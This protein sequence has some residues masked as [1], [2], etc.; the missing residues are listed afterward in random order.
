MSAGDRPRS[1]EL[2]HALKDAL[3]VQW[4]SADLESAVSRYSAE[5]HEVTS[6]LKSFLANCSEMVVKWKVEPWAEVTLSTR[7]EDALEE[8]LRTLRYYNRK[9]GKQVLQIGA[10]YDTEDCVLLAEDDEI[11]VGSDAGIQRIGFGFE[12]A[13]R[14]LLGGTWDKTFCW[15]P[16]VPAA[17]PEIR[18]P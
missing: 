5:G 3:S 14:A 11:L 9:I 15:K 1:V 12:N 10:V 17:Y 7:V 8:P 6:W 18:D 2:Q 4:G 16:G 13:L